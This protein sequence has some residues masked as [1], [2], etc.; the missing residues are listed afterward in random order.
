MIW[1]CQPLGSLHLSFAPTRQ[2][3]RGAAAPMR[4]RTPSTISTIRSANIG[5]S[6]VFAFPW[7]KKK[8]RKRPWGRKISTK[9][10]QIWAPQPSETRVEHNDTARKLQPHSGHHVLRQM[11]MNDIW[12]QRANHCKEGKTEELALALSDVPSGEL[13]FCYGKSPCL[14][15]KSTISTGPFS[16]ANCFL[17][18]SRWCP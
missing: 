9:R 12:L 5:S 3:S 13:T 4:I 17:W 7:Q 10:L 6:A 11:T 8:G 15:G 18:F 2:I 16:I 1:G 14:L